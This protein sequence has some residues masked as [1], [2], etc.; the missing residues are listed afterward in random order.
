MFGVRAV[1]ELWGW[2][3]HCAPIWQP[4][5]RTIAFAPLLALLYFIFDKTRTTRSKSACT[6]MIPNSWFDASAQCLRWSEHSAVVC[7]RRAREPSYWTMGKEKLDKTNADAIETQMFAKRLS[8]SHRNRQRNRFMHIHFMLFTFSFQL[9][10]RFFFF[11][12]G[13]LIARKMF[14]SKICKTDEINI[15]FCVVDCSICQP[16]LRSLFLHSMVYYVKMTIFQQ[17]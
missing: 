2:R 12:L 9:S 8:C 14:V 11:F 1:C 17:L 6:P 16:S 15:L 4:F 7:W 3:V 5:A 10:S 13:E